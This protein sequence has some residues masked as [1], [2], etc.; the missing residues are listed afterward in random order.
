M[1]PEIQI[2][3]TDL[4]RAEH[5][6]AFLDLLDHYAH[7]PMGG[8]TGLSAAARRELVPRLQLQPGFVGF[9]AWNAAAAAGLI[10]CFEGFSTFAARPLL[11]VHDIVVRDGA[12]GAGIGQ[13]LLA[14][15]EA[16]ARHRGCCK[17]TLEVLSNNHR[18]LA[19]YSRFGFRPYVLDPAA[20]QAVFLQK[21]L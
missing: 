2:V 7:D 8:G 12:R 1:P 15:A 4:G 18:A 9:M 10:N 17:L 5:A 3:R 14:A 11:N 6:A 20:G 13:A 19:S 16:E 21:C